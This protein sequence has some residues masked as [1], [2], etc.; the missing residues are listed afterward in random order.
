MKSSRAATSSLDGCVPFPEQLAQQVARRLVAPPVLADLTDQVLAH[1]GRAD[2]RSQVVGRV[3]AGVHVGDEPVRAVDVAG[4]LGQPVGVAV[5][6][7]AVLGE[8]R[9]EVE[10]ELQ[11][12]RVAPE[13]V[14][15][16][17][18]RRLG[19]LGRL[20]RRK[21][22]VMLVPGGLAGE[23]L[24][25]ERVDLRERVVAGQGTE[26][27]RELR[28]AAGVVQRV[29]GLVEEA[30]VVGQPALRPR[31][32]VDDG[33]RVRR[34]HARPRRLLRAIVEVGAD[35]RVTC[36]VEAEVA[37]R[38]EAYLDT[39]LLRIRVGER[40]Q[41]PDVGGVK[42]GRRRRSVRPQQA[43]EPAIAQLDVGVL[44]QRAALGD[45][46][47]QLA[48]RD[49]LVLLA[50][51]NGILDSGQL[52]LHGVRRTSD[53]EPPLVHRRRGVGVDLAQLLAIGVFVEHRELRVGVP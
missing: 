44:D 20:L 43:V 22:E 29:A 14:R 32:Q 10:L 39:A 12:R 46:I 4:G 16:E 50:A 13:E 37:E 24:D 19:V 7:A 1:L 30:P 6:R 51:E 28:V 35:V 40:R 42:G 25:E 49:A 5:R 21:V 9:P 38:G 33:G 11:L 15:V 47:G 53:L 23:R 18:D 45:H 36:Q 3:E 52:H 8:P 48:Q 2:P 34:D 26:G 17:E 31:D 27:V 41:P